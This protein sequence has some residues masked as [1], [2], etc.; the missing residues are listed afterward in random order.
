MRRLAPAQHHGYPAHT[1][2]ANETNFDP[3]VVG[4]DGDNRGEC[5]PP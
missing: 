4:L 2:A 3:R 5:Q 1:F